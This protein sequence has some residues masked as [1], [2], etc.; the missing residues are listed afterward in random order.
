MP[1]SSSQAAG[2]NDPR[3]SVEQST[4]LVLTGTQRAGIWLYRQANRLGL[5]SSSP[6]RQLFSVA[7][8]AYKRHFEDPF[9]NLV[10]RHPEFFRG[11]DVIDVGANMGYTASVFAT[12]ID[13]GCHVWAFEPS[14]ANFAQLEIAARNRKMRDRVKANTRSSG[15]A[16]WNDR[17]FVK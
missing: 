12:A 9:Q 5:L 8:R 10:D 16:N 6:A 11:G 14:S 3:L 4:I 1:R 2:T 15:R 13:A 7:Y 17:P